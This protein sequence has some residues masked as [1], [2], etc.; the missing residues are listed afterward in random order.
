MFDVIMPMILGAFI[1]VIGILNMNGD[2]RSLHKYHRHRVAP[3]DIKT[4]GKL[5][6]AGTLTCGAG[7]IVFG[8]FELIS[9][10]MSVFFITIVGSVILIVSVVIGL[11]I[12]IFSMIKYN[13]GIF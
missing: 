11:V 6:G 1:T 5:V 9:K 4:Y 3:E 2:V 8:I 13:K 10:L 7:L 12:M